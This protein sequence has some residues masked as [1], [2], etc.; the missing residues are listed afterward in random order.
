MELPSDPKDF[1]A[2][3]GR[4]N[5]VLDVQLSNPYKITKGS[6]R[7]ELFRPDQRPSVAEPKDSH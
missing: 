6:L 5:E 7:Y 3:A 2:L 4:W 1:S